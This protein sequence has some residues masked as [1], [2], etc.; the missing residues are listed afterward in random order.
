MSFETLSMK[1]AFMKYIPLKFKIS[2]SPILMPPFIQ[3]KKGNV[4]MLNY[5]DII[6]VIVSASWRLVELES[7]QGQQNDSSVIDRL[8][9]F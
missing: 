7:Q 5:W 9:D 6:I 4:N 2:Y 3:K 8:N 1:D